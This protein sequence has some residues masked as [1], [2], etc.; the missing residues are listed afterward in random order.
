M[1]FNM[2]NL[3]K[4]IEKIRKALPN[5]LWEGMINDG[6]DKLHDIPK[7]FAQKHKLYRLSKEC[8]QAFVEV[9]FAKPEKSYVMLK[10]TVIDGS[11]ERRFG[12]AVDGN[13]VEVPQSE[14]FPEV[15]YL[16]I[17]FWQ[18]KEEP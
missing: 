3:G 2:A 14:M 6:N 16:P 17:V 13:W 10:K 12:M 11:T 15:C 7:R 9:D 5:L 1:E 4:A 8:I 18:S